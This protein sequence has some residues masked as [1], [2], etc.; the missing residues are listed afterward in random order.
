MSTFVS[1]RRVIFLPPTFPKI[2]CLCGSTRFK[3]EFIAANFRE[4][5]AGNIV[6]SVGLYGHADASVYA[7]TAE[8]KIALDKL[9]KDK[10][11]L[12]D[13]VL[14]LNCKVLSCYCCV[15]PLWDNWQAVWMNC[16][17]CCHAEAYPRP[18]IGDSTRSEIAYAK[19]QGKVIRYLEES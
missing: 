13:E 15:R 5:M 12:A 4:T 17:P 19:E 1:D 3:Q 18:Y 10:I 2:V 7:P 6:L 8:E 9:H 14:V 11:F 16:T